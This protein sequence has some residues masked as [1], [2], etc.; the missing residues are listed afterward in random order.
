MKEGKERNS[1]IEVLRIISM[2]LVVGLHYLNFGM[3]VLINLIF[4][5]I[6]TH[7]FESLGIIGVNIFVL[8]S[9]YFLV[10]KNGN[11][12]MTTERLVVT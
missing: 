10:R 11:R 8:I 4:N 1:N 7:L 12:N 2:A 3:G 9:G 6:W 5:K